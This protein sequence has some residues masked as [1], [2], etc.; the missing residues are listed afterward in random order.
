M[1]S[2]REFLKMFGISTAGAAVMSSLGNSKKVI[3]QYGCSIGS[4]YK[5]KSVGNQIDLNFC[6]GYREYPISSSRE[7][8]QQLQMSISLA[9]I[10]FI[11]RR[12]K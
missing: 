4:G 12:Q 5:F 11:K 7:L 8:Y 2:R 9:D 10:W 3:Q 6:F 1:D